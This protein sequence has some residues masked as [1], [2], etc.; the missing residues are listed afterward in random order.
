MQ[1]VHPLADDR[2]ASIS[3][4][5]DLPTAVVLLNKYCNSA[6]YNLRPVNSNPIMLGAEEAGR[7]GIMKAALHMHGIRIVPHARKEHSIP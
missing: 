6:E 7:A 1:R 5:P 3:S 4:K 2:A